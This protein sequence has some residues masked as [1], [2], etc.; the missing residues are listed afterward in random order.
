M[1]IQKNS[2]NALDLNLLKVFREVYQ[3]RNVTRASENLAMTQ[4]AV[5]RA[6]DRLRHIYKEKLFFRKGGEMLPTRTAQNIAPFVLA[7][8]DQLESSVGLT[9]TFDPSGASMA[10]KLGA[11]DYVAALILPKLIETLSLQA[12]SVFLS[13][14]PA[15]YQDAGSLLLQNKI[16]C[17]IVSSVPNDT[18]IAHRP[19]LHEEYVVISEPDNP[20]LSDAISF[21]EYL[22]CEHVL[23]SY[24]GKQSGWVDEQLDELGLQRKVV[25]SVHLFAAV[26]HIIKDKPYICT[27][28]RRIAERLSMNHPLKIHP[29]P[30]PLKNS[31]YVFSLISLRSNALNPTI[32]W[33]HDK[34]AEICYEL[35]CPSDSTGCAD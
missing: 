4:P 33:I 7:G 21:D 17:A 34:I 28:P 27:V 13:T 11:N 23:V 20:A 10:F 12:P 2:L 16:D 9:R 35:E 15:T 24:S 8:L 29:L 22:A 18:R 26:P 30:S 6:L 3:A 5:S 1:K 14:V 31:S 19:V 25:T 32:E